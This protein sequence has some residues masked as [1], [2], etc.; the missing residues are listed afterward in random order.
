MYRKHSFFGC[1]AGLALLAAPGPALS[2]SLPDGLTTGLSMQHGG[3]T[4][5]FDVYLP[6]RSGM[7]PL[8]VDLHG[9]FASGDQ[10][11]ADSGFLQLAQAEG[12]AVAWPDSLGSEW[13]SFPGFG[14]EVDDVSFLRA[15]VDEL[16]VSGGIDPLR[17]YATGQ[18][19]GAAMAQRLA[20]D[21]ADVFAAFVALAAATPSDQLT[22]A[23]CNPS[24]P[25]PM[26]TM[27]STS[28]MV[29]P[30]EGGQTP[31]QAPAVIPIRGAEEELEWWRNLAGCPGEAPPVVESLGEDSECS[32]YVECS[33]DVE[34]GMCSV[35]STSQFGHVLYQNSDG[36]DLAQ[37]AWS[38]MEAYSLQDVPGDDVTIDETIEGNWV[39]PEADDQGLMFDYIAGPDVLFV[40]WFTYSEQAVSP[41]NPP[42]PVVGA[43]GQ[44]WLAATLEID[45]ATATGDL[46]APAGGAFLQSA[47]PEQVSPV[48]GT[49]TIEF[50]DCDQA[51]V[52]YDLSTAD[53]AGSFPIEPLGAV[54]AG[55]DFSC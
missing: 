37:R 47:M 15:L 51:Q 41:I 27:R 43:P 12:F 34:V 22:Q 54:V 38:F 20:C 6:D 16:I 29:L 39:G 35:R 55:E 26:L 4:R 21:A 36:L 17:V 46:V 24:R 14:P 32:R 23:T 52:S 45:G 33:A 53:R 8:V 2:Q 48:V 40:A 42:E 31:P 30:Y 3:E 25:V 5:T 7:V 1:L 10:Q 28:D 44:R 18:S 9:T 13:A 50:S 19:N 49:I 11:R